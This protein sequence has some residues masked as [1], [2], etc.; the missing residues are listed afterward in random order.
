MEHMPPPQITVASICG[1][2]GRKAVADACS[3]GATQVSNACVENKF[4]AKWYPVIRDLCAGAAIECPENLF[5]FISLS[6]EV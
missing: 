4:P 2:I 3:V 1:I 6:R 5:A